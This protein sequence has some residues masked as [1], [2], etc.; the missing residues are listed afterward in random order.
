MKKTELK[1]ILKPL[2]KECIKEVIFEDG[3]LSG[4]IS[5]VAKG[6]SPSSVV[7]TTPPPADPM[8]DRLKRNAFTAEQ[9]DN[10]KEHKAKLMAA[11]GGGGNTFNGVN[12]FEGTTP[13][14]AQT[15]PTQQATPLSGVN[16]GDA[17]VDI[18]GLFGG[19]KRHWNAHLTDMKKKESR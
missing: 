19:A 12:L 10:L 17:G 11:I 8:V 5:E 16:P 15:T 9:N 13:V 7:S 2:I 1:K 18:S 4:L 14:A 3:V 6:M